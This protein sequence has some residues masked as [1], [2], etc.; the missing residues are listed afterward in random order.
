MSDNNLYHVTGNP[1]VDM[2]L[3]CVEFYKRKG[4][5]TLKAINLRQDYYD[6]F[7][8]HIAGNYYENDENGNAVSKPMPVGL[9]L[10]LG[11]IDINLST[12]TYDPLYPEFKTN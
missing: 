1:A 10:H 7:V 12:E 4:E 8:E 2:T 9:Q 6:L 3:A 5:K 11:D